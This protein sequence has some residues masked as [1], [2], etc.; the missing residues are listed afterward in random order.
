M[1]KKQLFSGEAMKTLKWF[2]VAV[3]VAFVGACGPLTSERLSDAK[4]MKASGSAF[5]MALWKGYVTEAEFELTK[6]LEL[7][8]ADLFLD[9]AMMAGKGQSPAPTDPSKYSSK[10]AADRLGALGGA[11][12]RLTKGLADNGTQKAP[13]KAAEAQVAFDCW[14]EEEREG[15][16]MKPRL[17]ECR[18]RFMAAMDAVEAALKTAAPAPTPAPAPAPAPIAK[19][20]GPYSVH[21]DW[22]KSNL[23]KAAMETI[24]KVVADSKAGKPS[25]I[26]VTGYTDTSGTPA[27]NLRL[28]E[29]RAEVVA[30][31]LKK[32]G[33]TTIVAT[34]W[35]GE[36]DLAI[37]TG[38]NVREAKNRRTVIVLGK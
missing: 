25:V 37:P 13:E 31:A 21:F 30:K 10:I 29:K 6:Q 28:S 36:D 1:P 35:V 7:E 34:F 11:Y 22:N 33:A 12:V 4:A 18:K 17:E 2:A 15:G 16:H 9:K 19:M 32:A 23:D 20:P 26:N 38:P 8:V 27:Y 14:V 5:Q 3:L 24:D